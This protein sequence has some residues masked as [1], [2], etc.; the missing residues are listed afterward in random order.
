MAAI[1][2]DDLELGK[3]LG[4][5]GFGT[6]Y[7][8]VWNKTKNV[9]VKVLNRADFHEIKMLQQLQHPNIVTLYGFIHEER[10]L[11]IVME[12]CEIGSL[13]SYLEQ[14][15]HTPLS[16]SLI[17]KWMLQAALPID[18]LRHHSVQH[19]DIKTDN[20]VI[21]SKMILKLTDF[22]ISQVLEKTRSF[23]SEAGSW[24]W[25]SPERLRD[26]IVCTKFDIY[27]LALVFWC[28]FTRALPYANYES[29]FAIAKAVCDNKVR[30]SIPPECPAS[31]RKLIEACWDDNR[32]KRPDIRDVIIALVLHKHSTPTVN[33]CLR[34]ASTQTKPEIKGRP[35]KYTEAS[36]Q[37]ESNGP[38]DGKLEYNYFKLRD[39]N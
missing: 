13:R 11:M 32:T 17:H 16:P 31:I 15:K 38:A 22:G 19:M 33:T 6:V 4:A 39:E 30:P 18:Y 5:G 35:H 34:H 21:T 14:H 28:L 3:V 29:E 7:C 26:R 1:A 12:L 23:S 20:Y 36:T 24:R 8:G 25:M 9:A 27:A 10:D 2:R 37:T